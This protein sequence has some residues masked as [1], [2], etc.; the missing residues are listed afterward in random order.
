MLG[1]DWVGEVITVELSVRLNQLSSNASIR[2]SRMLKRL[3][4][5]YRVA[6]A[7]LMEPG[8]ASM[9]KESHF[10]VPVMPVYIGFIG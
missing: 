1:M 6:V 10:V 3:T 8:T 2:L 9:E 4:E 7:E 5:A